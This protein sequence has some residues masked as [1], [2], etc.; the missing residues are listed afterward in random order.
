M[1]KATF[2]PGPWVS[3]P[4]GDGDFRITYNEQGNWLAEVFADGA[5]DNAIAD[6]RLIAAAPEM[7]EALKTAKDTIRAW[8]G[9]NDWEIYDRSSPE[10]KAINAAIAKAEGRS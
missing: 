8:H 5:P 2:T 1:S 6:A 7:L 4:T 3:E 9:P 10:M